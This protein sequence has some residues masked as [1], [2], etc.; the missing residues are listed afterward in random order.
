MYRALV[1]WIVRLDDQTL[2]SLT[3]YLGACNGYIDAEYVD[4]FVRHFYGIEKKKK[5]GTQKL[6]NV[7]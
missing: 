1:S 4:I 6:K 3:V 2:V 7:S 5:K